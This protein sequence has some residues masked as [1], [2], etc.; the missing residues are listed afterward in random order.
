MKARSRFFERI[1]EINP[2][3]EDP[4]PVLKEQD[5]LT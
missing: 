1:E 2:L 4:A 5:T 3:E